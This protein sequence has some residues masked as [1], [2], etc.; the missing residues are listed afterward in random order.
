MSRKWFRTGRLEQ[1]QKKPGDGL[2]GLSM[3]EN[4]AA[5]QAVV[6]SDEYRNRLHGGESA[7]DRK[8]PMKHKKEGR[9]HHER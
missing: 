3:P 4:L 1:K 8:H 6:N 9:R 7:W 5:A 2:L